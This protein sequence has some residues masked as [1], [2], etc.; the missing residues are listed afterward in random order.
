MRFDLNRIIRRVEGLEMLSVPFS[1]E[2]IDAVIKEMPGD[3]PPHPMVSIV[4]FSKAVG[5]LSRK[6]FIK[7][8]MT[9][10]TATST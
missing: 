3:R 10:M 4:V 1:K 2:E 5:T 9:F 6:I 8:A 7:C